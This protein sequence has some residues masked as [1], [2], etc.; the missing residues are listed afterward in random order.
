M[1]ADGGNVQRLTGRGSYNWDPHWSPDGDRIVFASDR[2]GDREVF[3]MNADGTHIRQLTDNTATDWNASWSPDGRRIVFQSDRD[4]DEEIFVMDS[5]GANQRQLTAN[6]SYDGRPFWSPDGLWI[7]FDSRR[8]GDNEIFVMDSHGI[9]QRRVTDTPKGSTFFSDVAVGDTADTAIG[10][11]VARG[12]T[13]G[14]GQGRFDPAGTVTRAQ[15][16]TF[17]HRVAS[18]PQGR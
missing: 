14:V 13:S 17:L 18:L 7:A 15:I 8:D 3:V 11:A 9:D 5:D 16:V 1:D 4:G 10:W 6:T 2:D 12:V